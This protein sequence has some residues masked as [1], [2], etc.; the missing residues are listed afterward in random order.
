MTHL[1]QSC[2][3]GLPHHHRVPTSEEWLTG[4]VHMF[5]ESG[6]RI[7]QARRAVLEW[8]APVL[9]PFTAETIVADL[10]K[11]P[12]Y[13]SRATIYRMVEWLCANGWLVRVQ[14]DLLHNSYTR[15]FPGHHHMLICTRC[16]HSGILGGCTVETLLASI[17]ADAEFEVHGHM[18]ELYGYC[19]ACRSTRMDL[20]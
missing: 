20:E 19:K 3:N 17:M 2:T 4:T 18:L 14:S 10:A 9:V 1:L 16:G 13:S 8:I 11:P 15:V 7:T 6:G 12:G 5:A